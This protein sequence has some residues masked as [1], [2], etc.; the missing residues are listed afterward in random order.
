MARWPEAK[1][2]RQEGV[3][4]VV[5][6]EAREER[7]KEAEVGGGEGRTGQSSAWRCDVAAAEAH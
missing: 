2:G 7:Q 4:V 5:A 6:G 3:V 1:E